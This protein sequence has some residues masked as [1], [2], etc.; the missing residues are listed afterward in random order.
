MRRC[1]LF[2][3]GLIQ[4]HRRKSQPFF[5]RLK[6][7]KNIQAVWKQ[8][9]S[10]LATAINNLVVSFD[11]NVILGG[12]LGEYLESYIDDIRQSVAKITTFLGN[13]DYITACTYKKEAAAVGAALLYIRP[14][15][16]QL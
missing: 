8:Y 14:F 1:I 13:E 3:P 11:C 9:L 16:K 4:T 12:Y 7:D 15:I 10:Y 6:T 5:E 2:R